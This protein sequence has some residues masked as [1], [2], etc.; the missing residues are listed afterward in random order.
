MQRA[1]SYLDAN[2]VGRWK[3]RLIINRYDKHMGL[4]RDVIATALHNDVY[5]VIPNDYEAVQRALMEGKPVP[6]STAVGKHIMGL[7]D[8]LAGR[9]ESIKKGSSLSG[10]LSLFSRT[11]S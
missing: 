8:R 5:Y 4:A 6:S 1:F 2:G 11:S 3:I 9:E 7:A 10:L